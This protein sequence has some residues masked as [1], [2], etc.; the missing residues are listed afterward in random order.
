MVGVVTLLWNGTRAIARRLGRRC[1]ARLGVTVTCGTFGLVLLVSGGVGQACS[2][3]HGLP[4]SVWAGYA[5]SG[6]GITSVAATWRVPP[7][8]GTRGR[9]SDVA[10]WVGLAG[11]GRDAIEQIGTEESVSPSGV[12]TVLAWYELPSSPPVPIKMPVMVGDTVRAYAVRAGVDHVRLSFVNN[13]TGITWNRLT[14]A[15]NIG[16]CNGAVMVE[17]KSLTSLADFANVMFTR[18]EMNMSSI[19]QSTVVRY[20]IMSPSGTVE[21]WTSPIGN[22][23]GNFSVRRL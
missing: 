19:K 2:Q 11:L 13:T 7:V 22:A 6:G 20:D 17:Q 9:S 3:P 16:D 15:D 4:S 1:P 23:Q 14:Y 18:C 21:T 10:F 12:S 8:E 5:S